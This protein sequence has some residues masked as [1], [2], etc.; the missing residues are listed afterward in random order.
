MT[1]RDDVIGRANVSDTDELTAYY[2][3]LQGLEAGALWTVANAIEPWEPVAHAVPCLWRFQDLRPH[4]LRSLDL[5]TPEKAG[6]RV[7]YLCNPKR[8]DVSAAVGWLYTGLQAMRPGEFTSAHRHAASALRFIMEGQGAY[9][10]V[11]GQRL[12]LGARDF[13]LTPSGA[14]HEHGVEAD[15]QTSLWQ[16][17]LDIPLINALEANDYAVHPDMMQKAEHPTDASPSSYG[18]PGLLPVGSRWN[19]NYSPLL[20]Y[21]WDATYEALNQHARVADG[22]PFD[23]IVMRYV[24]PLTGG[25]VMNTMGAQMQMLRPGVH[26]KAHRHTG[27]I[28]YNVAKGRGWS[29]IAGQR[30]EWTQ[31]DIFVVP[32]WAWHEHTNA[33]DSED[34]CLFSF[35]D[36]PVMNKLGLYQEQAYADNGGHQP[37]V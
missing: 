32:S 36:L 6:R 12:S 4:V 24:N 13:V 11:D 1:H 37:T 23:D 14:W 35:D 9:T 30:F 5:V 16:D 26:T 2:E 20:K 15:G 10:V 19:R 17:G 33:S 8:R 28:V 21:P 7:V 29:V 27:N 34:A 25:D 31:G 22:T 3:T 18:H